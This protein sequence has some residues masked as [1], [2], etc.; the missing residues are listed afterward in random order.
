ME[1][2]RLNELRVEG[3]ALQE[4]RIDRHPVTARQVTVDTLQSLPVF[5]APVWRGQDAGQQQLRPGLS[6]QPLTR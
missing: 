2:V 3:Y 5:L 1:P 6:S 4:K